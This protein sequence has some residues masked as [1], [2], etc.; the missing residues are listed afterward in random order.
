MGDRGTTEAMELLGRRQDFLE[1]L[2]EPAEKPA[3]VSEL[4]HSRSTVDRAIRTLESAGFVERTAEGYRTTVTGRLALQ[5]YDRYLRE[6]T[7]ILE[8]EPVLGTLPPTLDLPMSSVS[9]GDVETLDDDYRLFEVLAEQLSGADR[10]RALVPTAAD[11]RHLRLLHSHVTQHELDGTV[12]ADDAVY[13]QLGREF[14]HLTLDLLDSENCSLLETEK[15]AFGLVYTESASADAATVLVVAY[16]SGRPVG[17]LQSSDAETVAWATEQLEQR[18]SGARAVDTL[19]ADSEGG[20]Y[21]FGEG[22]PA[23]LRSQGFERVDSAYFENRSTIDP[24]TSLRAGLKLPEVAA[25][26][27]VDRAR[28][29]EDGRESV[30]DYL[31]EQLRT[32]EDLLLVGPP[33]SGKSTICKQVAYRWFHDQE[34]VVFYRESGQGKP[35]EDVQQLASVL[36]RES[37][38]PLVVVE[39]AIRTDASEIFEV[40]GQF[41]DEVAFLFDAREAEWYDGEEMS[42]TATV[43]VVPRESVST[44]QVPQLD[45]QERQNI[46]DTVSSVVGDVSGLYEDDDDVEETETIFLF[47]HRLARSID[48]L[49]GIDDETPTTLDEHVDSLRHRLEERGETALNVGLLV[50]VL[51]AAEIPVYPEYLY[52]LGQE[53]RREEIRQAIETLRGEVLFE[54]EADAYRTVHGTWSVRFLTRFLAAVGEERTQ[55]MVA[56]AARALLSLAESAELRERVARQSDERR[57]VLADVTTSPTDWADDIVEQLF[58]LGVSYPKLSGLFGPDIE[59]ALALP[60]ATSRAVLLHSAIQRADMYFHAGDFERARV[61]CERVVEAIADPHGSTMNGKLYGWANYWLCRVEHDLDGQNARKRGEIALEA[62]E[63][64]GHDRGVFRTRLELAT[65]AM[66]ERELE[67]ASTQIAAALA[68]AERQGDRTLQA[69][70]LYAKG[71]LLGYKGEDARDARRESVELAREA[72]ATKQEMKSAFDLANT[73][74]MHGN[75]EAAERHGRRSLELARRTGEQDILIFANLMLG[76][77]AIDRHRLETAEQHIDKVDS[78]GDQLPGRAKAG[79]RVARG[80]LERVRGNYEESRELLAGILEID[81]KKRGP[82][83]MAGTQFHLARTLVADGDVQGAR[84][85]AE[86]AVAI[87]EE[88]GSH[89]LLARSRETLGR[90][91]LAA[92]N[93]ERAREEFEAALEQ[94][95]QTRLSIPRGRIEHGLGIVAVREGEKSQASQWYETALERLRDA[96]AARVAFE[97]VDSLANIDEPAKWYTVAAEIAEDVGLDERAEDYRERASDAGEPQQASTE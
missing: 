10:Y 7:R 60:E 56:K 69:A 28:E 6:T 95:E 59:S 85:H 45:D 73:E 54:A 3:L 35:F 44:V 16:E 14:P 58:A 87:A 84:D 67:E 65:I 80:R 74:R 91:E 22:L 20:L 94:V 61:E 43:E 11:S 63:A 90:V 52:T 82:R 75:L 79:K 4:G 78:Y 9:N 23:P 18:R 86:E 93:T 81:P 48:L 31:Y 89:E 57:S 34:G 68:L 42:N 64:A 88:V 12:L 37:G 55:A 53:G 38:R 15:P 70:A 1:L 62:F 76:H 36:E 92:G 24:A 21:Q 77:T 5:R 51:N 97:V 50:N 19:E 39:D 30:T 13:Q 72:G 96:G 32:G 29:T 8:S 47:F 49:E 83:V 40:M 66:N 26:Y 41:E 33:G 2:A 17:Y 46:V 25:G 27:A 71:K